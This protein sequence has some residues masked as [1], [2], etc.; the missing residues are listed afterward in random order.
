MKNLKRRDIIKM[1]ALG[2]GV[3]ALGSVNIR[4]LR[5]AAAGDKD[6]FG[7]SDTVADVLIIG[8]GNAGIPAAIQA[9]DLG[10]GVVLLDKNPFVGGMLHIS[11]G[12][13]S[14]ADSKIQIAKG[15]EDSPALH[16]RD[17]MRLGRYR[18]NSE[19]L[20]LAVE[21]AAAMVDWLVEIGVDFTP[22]SPFHE[23]DHDRY[24]AA[25]TYAGPDYARSLLVPFLRELEKRIERG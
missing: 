22:E 20:K 8:A 13:I 11:G 21:N 9:A 10:A 7:A 16:Y 23:D 25:R 18:N 14:G 19:L 17:A 24:S 15:I 6:R 5:A 3:G 1:A 2:T 4:Q 12:H